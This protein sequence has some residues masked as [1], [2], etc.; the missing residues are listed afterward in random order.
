MKLA[1]VL[2][3]VFAGA[4]FIAVTATGAAA[5]EEQGRGVDDGFTVATQN[6]AGYAQ[7]VDYG[8][9]GSG[10]GNNDDYVEID[11]TWADGWDIWVRVTQ[12]GDSHYKEYKR[13]AWGDVM[14]WDPFRDNNVKPGDT[15]EIEVC[16]L[17]PDSNQHDECNEHG[18]VSADG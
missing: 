7:Y 12:N 17:D 18:D 8:K 13:G 1:R 10:G 3:A 2:S 15:I 11:D 4:A 14:V 9:G 5:A 16:L 6:D